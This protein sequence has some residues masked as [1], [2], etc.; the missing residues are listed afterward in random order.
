MKIFLIF[1]FDF[2]KNRKKINL[3]NLWKIYSLKG[4]IGKLISIKLNNISYPIIARSGTSDLSLIYS[5][6]LK[7]EYPYF[8]DYSPKIIIDVGA[9]IGISSI[10]FKNCYPDCRIFA[11]EPESSNCIIFRQNMMPYNEVNLLC[12]AL[13]S[14]SKV[15]LDILDDKAEKYSF[16]MIQASESRIPTFSINEIVAKYDIKKIDILKI[17][18][19]GSEKD[20][21]EKNLEWLS[22]TDNI[23]IELHDHYREGCSQALIKAL[24]DHNF[25]IRSQ[26]ENLILSRF[27][28][29]FCNPFTH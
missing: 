10:Y 21:F 24:Y 27:P 18:I 22:I 16:K 5:I 20:V 6:L 7:Y 9:N 4:E 19:E 15:K 29:P 23:F 13:H 17:D 3:Y 26:G 14:D 1:I 25:T 12:G 28:T 11:I 8:K 2:I